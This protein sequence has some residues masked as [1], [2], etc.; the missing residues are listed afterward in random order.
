MSLIL[1]GTTG[2]SGVD[3]TA[4]TPALQGNDSNTGISFGT[5]TVTINTG[6]TARVTTDASGNVGIGTASPTFKLDL[7]GGQASIFNTGAASNSTIRYGNTDKNW[8]VGLRGDTSD[9]FAIADDSALRLIVDTSGNLGLG[10]TPSAWTGSGG[11]SFE[12]GRKGNSVFGNSSVVDVIYNANYDSA[13]KYSNTGFASYYQQSSGQH[14]WF[15][16]PSGTAGNAITFTQAMTLDASGNLGVGTTTPDIFGRFYT[17]SV[18]ISSSGTTALEINGTSYGTIDLGAGGVRTASLTGSSTEATL[19][20]NTAIPLVF[21]TNNGEKARI[22][23][24]GDFLISTT[25]NSL[26]SSA[27]YKFLPGND[28]Q[29]GTVGASSSNNEVTYRL[30][31]TGAGAYRFYVGYGGTVYATSAT[32]TSLSDQRLKE[33]I[34]DIDVGLDAVMALKP[35]KFDWKEGKGKNKK[36]DRGWIAQ[37]FEQVFPD[38]IDTWRDPAPEGEEPYKAVNADLIPVL[39]KAIQELT[40]RLEVLE[41]K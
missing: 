15:T 40:A 17:R 26:T 29:M 31:S 28:P 34:Q 27:G 16:A 18:G 13:W 33:N 2:V 38:M 14:Q 22:T 5:D 35:R 41:N 8:Y 1:N 6:G 11:F 25:N 36:G 4:G 9:V 3:G 39:V 37:E 24:G 12:I 32:I 21:S 30:Y 19:G 7:V 23:S 20:T 10:V